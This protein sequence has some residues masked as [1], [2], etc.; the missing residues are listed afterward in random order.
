LLS[1]LKIDER[2]M[3]KL[4]SCPLCA[5][6]SFDTHYFAKKIEER[7]YS[8]RGDFTVAVMGCVVNGPGEAGHADLAISGAGKTV[9]VYRKEERI[10]QGTADDAMGFFLEQLTLL[11]QKTQ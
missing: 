10:F 4:I 7:L 5:R 3:P 8:M 1:L 9:F 6:N 11:E 2:R